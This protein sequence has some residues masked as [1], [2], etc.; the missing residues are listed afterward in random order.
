M[1]LEVLLHQPRQGIRAFS[2]MRS[3]A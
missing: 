3:S 1:R 2:I